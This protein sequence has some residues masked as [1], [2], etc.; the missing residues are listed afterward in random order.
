MHAQTEFLLTAYEQE[1]QQGE[2]EITWNSVAEE[3]I[4]PHN[5]L[6]QS[7][8]YCRLNALTEIFSAGIS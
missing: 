7:T 4:T 2:E 3:E 8:N 5:L 6:L 1:E